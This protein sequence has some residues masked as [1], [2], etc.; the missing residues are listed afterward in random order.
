MLENQLIV[1]PVQQKLQTADLNSEDNPHSV[2]NQVG[3]V[4]RRKIEAALASHPH[5][6]GLS[7]HQF[8]K[9]HRV[10]T[11]SLENC[12]RLSFW[13]EYDDACRNGRKM[14]IASVYTGVCLRQTF[15]KLCT[16]A[17]FLAFLTLAPKAYEVMVQEALSHGLEELRAI[18]DMDNISETGKINTRIMD[19]KLKIVAMLDM[20][21]RGAVVQKNLNVNVNTA[22][23]EV[24]ATGSDNSLEKIQERIKLLE[25][26]DRTSRREI[27]L[28][29]RPIRGQFEEAEIVTPPEKALMEGADSSG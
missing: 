2:L 29:N 28:S 4:L 8:K 16:R 22:S 5:M 10:H 25:Q 27:D 3:D 14:H 17:E 19:L 13:K 6:F 21:V 20:R 7:E 23:K 1:D 12:L 26:L 24:S 11:G 18:L 15:E 9:E